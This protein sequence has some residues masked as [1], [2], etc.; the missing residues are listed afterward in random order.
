[1]DWLA[2]LVNYLR[3]KVIFTYILFTVFYSL[4]NSYEHVQQRRKIK[5]IMKILINRATSIT[6]IIRNNQATESPHVEQW[7]RT[8]NSTTQKPLVANHK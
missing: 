3:V 4:S 8:Q 7:P 6:S 5:E 1:V 2:Q